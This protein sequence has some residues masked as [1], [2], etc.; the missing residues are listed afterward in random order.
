M[1]VAPSEL[2]SVS[3]AGDGSMLLVPAVG[4][5]GPLL[6]EY[7]GRGSRLFTR[8]DSALAQESRNML[9]HALESRGAYDKG[10]TE[11]RSRITL[12]IHDNIAS[13]LISALHS[14]D[15]ESKDRRI[16][17][18]MAEIREMIRG[19]RTERLSLEESLGEFRMETGDR[20]DAAGITCV[21][22]YEGVFPERLAPGLIHA[23]RSVIREAIT[24]IIRHSG[25]TVAEILLAFSEDTMK[26]EIRDNG[27]GFDTGALSKGRGLANFHERL[28][29]FSGKA[30][31]SSSRE[32][33]LVSI[34]IPARCEQTE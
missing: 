14:A 33:T 22:K 21:W 10:V 18:T 16:R 2:S 34:Q 11:E 15:P 31:V 17:E 4:S 25:A 28:H 24:N 27:R 8:A 30:E 32:G 1:R 7:P 20:L 29:P 6:L 23:L 19:S 13:Q 9:S 5:A 3:I 12:D 26:L